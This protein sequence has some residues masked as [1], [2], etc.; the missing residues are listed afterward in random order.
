MSLCRSRRKKNFFG[1][2]LHRKS[3]LAMHQKRQIFDVDLSF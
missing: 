2:Y 3:V 1:L